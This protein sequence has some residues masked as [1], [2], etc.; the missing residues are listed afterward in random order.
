ML[1]VKFPEMTGILARDQKE[2][3]PLPVWQDQ[4]QTISQWKLD[5][6]DRFKLLFTGR[7]WLRQYHFGGDL[8]P[9]AP[10]VDY[11]FV[12]PPSNRL[13]R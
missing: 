2:Y 8:Q 11:P 6:R 5:W 10:S 9:Q 4:T 13:V 3:L 7:L 1:P 12:K